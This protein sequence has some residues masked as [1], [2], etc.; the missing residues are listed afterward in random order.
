MNPERLVSRVLFIGGIVSLVV[1][2]LGL[3]AYVAAAR[4]GETTAALDRIMAHEVKGHPA[5]VYSTLSEIRHGLAR[6]DA[7]AVT[8]LGLVLL[9]ATPVIGVMVAIVAFARARDH[10]YAVIAAIVL[11]VLMVSFILSGGVG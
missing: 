5:A 10:D 3:L 4:Q 2:V 7:L 6:R 11:C 8:A 9:A 1:L